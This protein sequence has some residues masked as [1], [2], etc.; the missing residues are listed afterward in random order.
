MILYVGSYTE[1]VAHDFGG[2]GEGIYC[3]DFDSS[4]GSLNLLHTCP[5]INPSYLTIPSGKYL[6]TLSELLW[7]KKPGAQAFEINQSDF[8]LHLISEQNIP[9]GCPCHI[10]FSKKNN[11]ILVA[12]YE[13]GNIICYPVA[14]DGK[15]MPY[16]NVIQHVGNSVD[17]LRQESAHPH[18]VFVDEGSNSILVPDLGMDKLMIYH[19]D[20]IDNP[21]KEN[22]KQSITLPPGSGPRHIAIHPK[23][24]FVYLVNEL[25]STVMV[26]RYYE[27]QMKPVGLYETLPKQSGVTPSGGAIRISPDGKFIYISE[28]GNNTVAVLRFDSNAET[29][30]M[31]D[32][33]ETMGKTPRDIHFDPGGNWL[34]AANQDSDSIAI[35]KIDKNSGTIKLE[36]L[37]EDI[38]SPVC[39]AWLSGQ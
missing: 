16:A 28:R 26:M 34:L 32:R 18:A 19:L 36:R 37:V 8:S 24:S 3:F 30:E 4:K 2:H 38:K 29:I 39:L 1:I 17:D 25:T 20:T 23:G 7:S 35:F 21:L 22:L 33:Q 6:Y 14:S 9:G 13:T 12:C 10:N 27:G 31:I 5:A 11:C 15:L